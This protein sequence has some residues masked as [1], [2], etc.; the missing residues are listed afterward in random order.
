VC[1]AQEIGQQQIV[2]AAVPLASD[3][4]DPV[5]QALGG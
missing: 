5:H 4:A 2:L 3:P 1:L